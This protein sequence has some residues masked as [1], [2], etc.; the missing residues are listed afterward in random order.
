MC[1][2]LKCYSDQMATIQSSIQM[3]ISQRKEDKQ[4]LDHWKDPR[5]HDWLWTLNDMTL[6]KSCILMV[7]NI[8]HWNM[9]FTHALVK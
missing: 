3:F 5:T 7:T 8:Y 1:H 6:Q 9:Q 4:S 2:V